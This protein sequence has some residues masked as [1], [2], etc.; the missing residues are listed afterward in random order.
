MGSAESI[1]Y[2]N[3]DFDTLKENH[4]QT[5]KRNETKNKENNN[6]YISFINWW[7]YCRDE[8]RNSTFKA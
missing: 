6:L 5:L 8:N 7:R 2:K 4:V 3:V 1:P